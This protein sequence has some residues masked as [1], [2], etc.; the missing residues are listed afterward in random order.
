[1]ASDG[2]LSN[3]SGESNGSNGHSTPHVPISKPSGDTTGRSDRDRELVIAFQR[4]DLDAY[5]E[6][7][8]RHRARVWAIC[9]R[10]L[11]DSQ[12]AEEATQETFL[13]SYRALARFNGNYQLGAWLARIATNIC[14]DQIRG[15]ARGPRVEPTEELPASD[16]GSRTDVLVTEQIQLSKTLAEIQP[17][18]AEALVMRAVG[19]LSHQEMAGA[20]S[21]ST[22]QVKSLLHRAR[23]SFRRAWQEASVFAL[24]PLATLRDLVAR[25]RHQ[26]PAQQLASGP[27]TAIT[28]ERVAAA[29]MA[30]IIAISGMS[31][32]PAQQAPEA[33]PS[34]PQDNL[35][36]P[37]HDG[38]RRQ[39]GAEGSATKPERP[40][41]TETVEAD[42]TEAPDLGLADTLHAALEKELRNKPK[43]SKPPKGKDG[44]IPLGKP[45][46]QVDE[47]RKEAQ[48]ALESLGR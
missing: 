3:G 23:M 42:V 43:A 27:L 1:M 5:T 39:V 25:A 40:A 21:M 9:R 18:H 19:G 47:V 28:V 7:Y 26:E 20:L 22:Q 31:S 38:D 16:D 37:P 33:K 34:W 46:E 24:A 13:R 45:T 17:L 15:R 44:P 12:D 11:H 10:L 32:G 6:I 36:L 29:G 30:A 48:E 2:R 4:G 14:V 41:P 8:R 35:A